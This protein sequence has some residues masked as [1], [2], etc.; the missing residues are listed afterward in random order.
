MRC[1]VVSTTDGEGTTHQAFAGTSALVKEQR[2]QFVKALGV[3]K[4]EVVVA[5]IDV[6]LAKA[7]LLDFMNQLLKGIIPEIKEKK[8]EAK[9][10]KSKPTG[11]K[12][13]KGTTSKTV[14]GT[15]SKKK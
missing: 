5:Q 4:N 14:R 13:N 8:D 2:D 10:T 1:Y 15:S 7:E 9:P 12:V 3:K 11:R 6:P